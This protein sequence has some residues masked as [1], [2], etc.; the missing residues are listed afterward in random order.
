MVTVLESDGKIISEKVTSN[1]EFEI[2]DVFFT[3]ESLVIKDINGKLY[4]L[5]PSKDSFKDLSFEVILCNFKI[6]ILKILFFI[7]IY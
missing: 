5:D 7:I 3:N 4:S 2:S 1:I 6:F